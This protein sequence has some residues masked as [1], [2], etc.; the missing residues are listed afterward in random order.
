[1]RELPTREGISRA[2]REIGGRAL[3]YGR[4]LDAEELGTRDREQL[5]VFRQFLRDLPDEKQQR[6]VGLVDTPE[7][8]PGDPVVAAQ[9]EAAK[10]VLASPDTG[11]AAARRPSSLTRLLA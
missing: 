1:V 2:L 11:P 7:R 6:R 5:Q 4:V 10:A 3:E 9:E 8:S